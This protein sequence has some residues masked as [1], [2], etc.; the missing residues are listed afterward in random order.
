MLN[1]IKLRL[2]KFNSKK[3]LNSFLINVVCVGCGVKL[4]C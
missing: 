1:K 4:D 3:G 2:K